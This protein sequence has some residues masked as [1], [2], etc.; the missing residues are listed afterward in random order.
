MFLTALNGPDDVG[1]RPY[2]GILEVKVAASKEGK[3]A[4]RSGTI[5]PMAVNDNT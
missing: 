2:S 3:Q 1:I 5:P 4:L